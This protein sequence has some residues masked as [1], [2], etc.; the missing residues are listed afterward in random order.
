M[1]PIPTDPQRVLEDESGEFD[2]KSRFT[3]SMLSRLF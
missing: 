2:N 3:Q 1:V